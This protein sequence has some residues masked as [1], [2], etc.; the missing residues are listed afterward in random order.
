[1]YD[2]TQLLLNRDGSLWV[3]TPTAAQRYVQGG[4]DQL[5]WG[6]GGMGGNAPNP[7]SLKHGVQ[8]NM[9]NQPARIYS[10]PMGK[11]RIYPD[12]GSLQDLYFTGLDG[13]IPSLTSV[14]NRAPMTVH[15][16]NGGQPQG[17]RMVIVSPMKYSQQYSVRRTAKDIRLQPGTVR[18]SRRFVSGIP[19]GS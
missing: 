2:R 6:T 5:G 12:M 4:S 13:G 10:P 7:Y 16:Q 15:T 1:M 18:P 3:G 19:V 11:H 14:G 17:L 8:N 9:E